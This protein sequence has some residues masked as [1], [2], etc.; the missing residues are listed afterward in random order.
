[1]HNLNEY[2]QQLVSKAGSELHLEPNKP[3]YVITSNGYAEISNSP[4]PGAQINTM[5]FSLIP[6]NIKQQLPNSSQVEFVH[7]NNL[8]DFNFL[9]KKSPSGFVVTISPPAGNSAA[10]QIVYT[11]EKVEVQQ[12]DDAEST[13]VRIKIKE[14]LCS[15]ML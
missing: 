7:S 14:W 12:L 2:L 4:L 1:M 9:V 15:M 10:K 6:A 11:E 8:G 5:I 13:S 3:P